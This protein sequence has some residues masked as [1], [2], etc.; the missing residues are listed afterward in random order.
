ME[1][2]KRK[3]ATLFRCLETVKESLEL[4]KEN[5][6]PAYEKSLK[7]SVIKRFEYT[8][9]NFW[10]FIKLYLTEHEKIDLHISSPKGILKEAVTNNIITTD[11]FKF[12]EQALNARNLTSHIYREEISLNILENIPVYYKNMLDILKRLTL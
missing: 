4:L 9:D 5:A 2:L 8:I 12:L 1:E 11:E 6:I 10:K 3:R 7:D